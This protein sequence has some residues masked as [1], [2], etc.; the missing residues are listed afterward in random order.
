MSKVITI[1]LQ[2][3]DD[4]IEELMSILPKDKV[5][6]IEED[7]KENKKL[8]EN[9]LKNYRDKPASFISYNES[10]KRLNNE[11]FKLKAI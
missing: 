8:L 2:V 11:Y 6:V 10:I 7:F 1:H 5:I 3:E 9:E 4:Y